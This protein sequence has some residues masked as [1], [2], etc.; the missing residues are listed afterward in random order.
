M[1]LLVVVDSI[2]QIPLPWDR[3]WKKKKLYSHHPCGCGCVGF[4]MSAKPAAKW[5]DE[6]RGVEATGE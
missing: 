2:W 6:M 5:R 4:Q 1:A 3:D